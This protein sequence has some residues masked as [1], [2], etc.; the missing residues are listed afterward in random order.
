MT[1]QNRYQWTPWLCLQIYAL[2]WLTPWYLEWR[3]AKWPAKYLTCI[4]LKII[5][6]IRF[7]LY[8]R[9]LLIRVHLTTTSSINYRFIYGL[10]FNE[11]EGHSREFQCFELSVSTY[12]A[13]HQRQYC[14][15][16]LS[17]HTCLLFKLKYHRQISN[18]RH[19]KSQ[20]LNA[21]RLVLQLPL[22]KQLKPGVKSRMTVYLKQR[23]QAMLQLQLNDALYCVLRCH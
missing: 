13:T 23:R 11:L 19:I 1:L 20:N 16:I 2:L 5:L 8:C 21:S 9:L 4:F 6:I 12:N 17:E 7:Q 15:T 18:I 10:Y 3:Q 22:R 14:G